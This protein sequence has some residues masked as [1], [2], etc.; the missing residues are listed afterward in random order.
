MKRSAAKPDV[1]EIWMV[2]K[3]DPGQ[4]VFAIRL[5]KEKKKPSA[6]ITGPFTIT[7][8]TCMMILLPNQQIEYCEDY[9]LSD[10]S[11]VKWSSHQPM[12]ETLEPEIEASK[13]FK[14]WE[15]EAMAAAKARAQVMLE[16]AV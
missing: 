13:K 10:D 9:T 15:K 1:P 6:Q 7:D 8:F 4:K 12:I 5:S 2:T 11:H 14:N 3:C 16:G